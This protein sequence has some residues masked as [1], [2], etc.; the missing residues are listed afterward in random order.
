[1]LQHR[2]EE[3][4]YVYHEKNWGIGVRSKDTTK[5]NDRFNEV[6]GGDKF[7]RGWQE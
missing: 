7:D 1:M 6:F 3:N 5:I 4:S 2:E